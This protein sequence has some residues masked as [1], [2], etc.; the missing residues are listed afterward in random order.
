MTVSEVDVAI[1][2]AG[3]AGLAA[4]RTLT[5]LGK[6]FVLLEASHRIGGRAYT[7]EILPG[8]PFDLGCHW[9]HSASLNPFVKIAD[10]LGFAYTKNGYPRGGFSDGKWATEQDLAD[11]DKF[12]ERQIRKLKEVA[13]SDS[14]C[15]IFDATE[16]DHRWTPNFDYYWSLDASHDVDEVSATGLMA[17]KETDENWPLPDGYGTLVARYGAGIP[18]SLNSAVT[19]IDWSGNRVK[20]ETANGTITAGSA[21]ITVST[22]IL[23]AGDIRFVPALPDWKLEAVAGLPIGNHNRICLG[24]DRDVF[25]AI[26]TGAESGVTTDAVDGVPMNF[27][28]RPD[29]CNYVVGLTGGRFADWLEK[30]G[31]QASIDYAEKKLQAVFGSDISKHVTSHIVTAWRGDPWIKGAYSAALPGQTHQRS[32]LARSL[33]GKLFFAGEA[34]SP[35]FFSTA[36]GAYLSGIAAAE[37][38]TGSS[39]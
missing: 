30:A 15:S 1:V 22:G 17:Y 10:E 18:V 4:A 21:L 16:R 28:V 14:D 29:D 6:S 23:A 31:Q 8:V 25:G 36:H 33:D 27:Y 24:F 3:A 20:L 34:T 38:V 11:F 2:G 39:S 37:S 13:A 19:S 7:E 5:Q 9:M 12:H 26:G 35:N 32:R